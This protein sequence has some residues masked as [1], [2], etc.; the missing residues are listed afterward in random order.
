MPRQL[1][2][3]II[4][5]LSANRNRRPSSISDFREK[6]DGIQAKLSEAVLIERELWR[7][8]EIL[9]E[10]IRGISYDATYANNEEKN[11]EKIRDD[12]RR[13]LPQFLALSQL[14]HSSQSWIGI[15]LDYTIISRTTKIVL[16]IE[17]TCNQI[18]AF[19]TSPGSKSGSWNE[20]L[21]NL[22][23]RT[24]EALR[25]ITVDTVA[26]AHDWRTIMLLFGLR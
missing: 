7:L 19:L 22:V 14:Q 5:G 13:T 8:S 24:L 10:A 23:A 26:A 12:L 11:A 2:D 1:C 9:L 25:S 20:L 6:L 18:D 15:V 17:A 3:L 21:K 16:K 4:H